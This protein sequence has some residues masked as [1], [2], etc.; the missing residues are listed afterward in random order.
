MGTQDKCWETM[1]NVVRREYAAR[2]THPREIRNL[3]QLLTCPYCGGK[4]FFRL[5]ISSSISR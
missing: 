2:C 4:P 1:R 3:A 5:P